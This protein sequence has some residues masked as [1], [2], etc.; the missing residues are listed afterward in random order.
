M[1]GGTTIALY[2]TLGP[3]AARFVCNQ[4]ELSTICCS[5]DLVIGLIKLKE[6]DPEGKMTKLVNIV[7][8][9]SDVDKADLD[10]AE[11]VGIKV[12][13]FD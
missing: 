1:T 2:D 11:K 10:R 3:D 7:S 6:E 4:T 13:T 5:K 8:F 12:T 9:E